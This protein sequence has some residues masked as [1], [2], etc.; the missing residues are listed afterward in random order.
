MA[1]FG[2]V[3][4]SKITA[5]VFLNQGGETE[6]HTS[7]YYHVIYYCRPNIKLCEIILYVNAGLIREI[8]RDYIRLEI[9]GLSRYLWNEFLLTGLIGFTF[10]IIQLIWRKFQKWNKDIL[11]L[12]KWIWSLDFTTQLISMK[13]S[14]CPSGI[15]SEFICC[16]TGLIPELS[17]LKPK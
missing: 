1:N 10:C 12:M 13:F 3:W 7:C 2:F 17:N 14:S 8:H 4:W 16:E 5:Q 11:L 15:A 9:F 6:A